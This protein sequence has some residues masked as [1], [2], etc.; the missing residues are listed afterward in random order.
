MKGIY[1]ITSPTNK[2]YIGQAVN[3]TDR[4][5]DYES[6]NCK[7]QRHLYNS[8]KKYGFEN[9]IFEILIGGD[10]SLQ[11]LNELEV[12]YIKEYN[13]YRGWTE[14][15]MNL[16][17]GGDQ[18]ERCEESKRIISESLKKFHAEVGHSE[19]TK[20]KIANTLTGKKL[21][22]ETISKQRISNKK[23]WDNVGRPYKDK[24][25]KKKEKNSLIREQKKL[26]N[27]QIVDDL[28]SGI[29]QDIIAEKYSLSPSVITELK[30][31]NNVQIET[32]MRRGQNNNFSKL[33]EQQ[34]KEIKILL[35]NKTKQQEIADLYSVKLRTIKA[36]SSGQ[37]WSHI[38]IE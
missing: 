17:T 1:K 6:Y 7:A 31:K 2:I 16:T 33:T 24:L 8:L 38:T 15:G 19:E 20:K 27:L 18:Y 9:H 12:K 5:K 11:E 22:E 34:V 30:K 37:N 26:R 3:L 29:R 13:S 36:I 25:R 14:N 28:K 23:Y 32:N 35:K 10:F 4:R 21:S